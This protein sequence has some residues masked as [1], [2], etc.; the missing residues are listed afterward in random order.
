[1]NREEWCVNKVTVVVWY[2]CIVYAIFRAVSKKKMLAR[3][4]ARWKYAEGVY[5][6]A[7]TTR[8]LP[9][10]VELGFLVG[11]VRALRRISIVS[12]EELTKR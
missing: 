6:F 5:W 11:S 9:L 2:N 10:I 12:N 7:N 8:I 3:A 4:M 1:M